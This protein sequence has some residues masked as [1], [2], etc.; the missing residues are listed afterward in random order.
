MSSNVWFIAGATSGFGKN[1]A[2][3]ALS[4]GDAVIATSR[5]ATKKLGSL[6]DKGALLIDLDVTAPDAEIKSA[7]DQGVAK[8]GKITHFINAA[9]YVLEGPLE[10]ASSR[11]IFDTFNSKY[12]TQFLLSY[13]FDL[14]Y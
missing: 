9:G 10:G 8:F 14:F 12:Q 2:L 6:A 11:D 4:R 7:L 13:I 3:E 1:I 5:T